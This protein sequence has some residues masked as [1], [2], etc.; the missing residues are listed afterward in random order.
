[1][2]PIREAQ[3]TYLTTCLF[4]LRYIRMCNYYINVYPGRRIRNLAKGAIEDDKNKR[5]NKLHE[6]NL[7]DI[8]RYDSNR[9][10]PTRN[11]V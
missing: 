2:T 3:E 10:T 11:N 5:L 9:N 6:I 7:L 8:Q 4:R 1:M